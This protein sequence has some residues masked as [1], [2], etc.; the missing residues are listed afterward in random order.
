MIFIRQEHCLIFQS[1]KLPT[2]CQIFV[3]PI[4]ITEIKKKVGQVQSRFKRDI[5]LQKIA[6]ISPNIYR[7][8]YIF[9]R[10]LKILPF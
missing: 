3:L 10:S 1:T 2:F 8:E 7:E 9:S 5:K 6:S 4:P